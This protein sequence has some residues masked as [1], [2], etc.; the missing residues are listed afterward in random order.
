MEGPVP[1]KR[2][3]GVHE[4]GRFAGAATAA[5]AAVAARS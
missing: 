2:L 1:D 4:P 3:G 5:A